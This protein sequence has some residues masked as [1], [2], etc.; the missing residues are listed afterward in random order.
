MLRRART[1]RDVLSAIVAGACAGAALTA[2]VRAPVPDGDR[3]DL[4][5]AGFGRVAQVQERAARWV[6]DAAAPPGGHPA[7]GDDVASA[8]PTRARAAPAPEA[9]APAARA[10]SAGMPPGTWDA[11]ADCESGHWRSGRPRPGTARWGYGSSAADD[12]FFEG[13]LG[14]HPGTWERYRQ[15]G[16][17]D[18][19]GEATREQQIAVAQRVQSAEGWGAWPAC[20]RKLG[21]R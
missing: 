9:I 13:G 19:A 5:A 18:H 21:L 14:F 15:P 20:S 4:V 17:P 6:D 1:R 8:E 7:P 12:G 10:G 3:D 16:M 11:L 2:L